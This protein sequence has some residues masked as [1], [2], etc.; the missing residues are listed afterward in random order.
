MFE[1]KVVLDS[2]IVSNKHYLVDWLGY[3]PNHHT[4]ESAKNL[5]DA[6]ELIIEFH[7]KF[8]N[9]PSLN[10]YIIACGTRRQC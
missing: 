5:D 4:W 1:V 10:S 2:K 6:S 8:P 3:T 7:C 9:K